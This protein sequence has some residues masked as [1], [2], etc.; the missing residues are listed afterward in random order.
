MIQFYIPDC[1]DCE[2][3]QPHWTKAAA[4]LQGKVKFGQVNLAENRYLKKRI[5]ERNFPSIRYFP[6]DADIRFLG[7]EYDGSYDYKSIIQWTSNIM[8]NISNPDI[9]EITNEGILINTCHNVVLCIITILPK[10]NQCPTMCRIKYLNILK[11]AAINLKSKFWG[12]L[13]SVE[14]DQIYLEQALQGPTAHKYPKLFAVNWLLRTCAEF[15][16]N[17]SEKTI[18][19]FLIKVYGGK[20]PV[21]VPKA[22][23]IPYIRNVQPWNWKDSDTPV[24]EHPDN[25]D[26]SE[27]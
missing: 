20:E 17:F 3:L 18:M 6:P 24:I 15:N 23:S 14:G 2:E 13:W 19:T 10:I 22:D 12:Y 11:N 25:H 16:G 7:V 9:V 5:L 1:H 4:E 27:F 26:E 21:Y 8:F